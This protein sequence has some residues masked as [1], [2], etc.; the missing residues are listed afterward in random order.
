MNLSSF[1]IPAF[2]EKGLL[3]RCARLWSKNRKSE[4]SKRIVFQD[5]FFCQ[6]SFVTA[7]RRTRQRRGIPSY[8]TFALAGLL[9]FL[10]FYSALQSNRRRSPFRPNHTEDFES[11]RPSNQS[12]RTIFFNTF[13]W[14]LLSLLFFRNSARWRVRP[15]KT[16]SG[17]ILFAVTPTSTRPTP[18]VAVA[19]SSFVHPFSRGSTPSFIL[20]SP[21][22]LIMLC[23]TT[24]ILCVNCKFILPKLSPFSCF[25][26]WKMIM[27]Q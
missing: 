9:S 18:G 19:L 11:A 1:F 26:S 5:V 17:T 2:R 6:L 24:K 22:Y 8:H 27:Y 16:A 7:D 15:S 13:V 4:N 12:S 3:R 14:L 20:P 25:S 10:L 23:L 21:Y